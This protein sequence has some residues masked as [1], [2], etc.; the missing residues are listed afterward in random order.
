MLKDE[1][2]N[3]HIKASDVW[4][5]VWS[6]MHNEIMDKK[7]LVGL[8]SSKD[9]EMRKSAWKFVTDR[10]DY[11]VIEKNE[12]KDIKEFFVEL[13]SSEDYKTRLNA[14]SFVCSLLHIGVIEKDDILDKKRYFFDLLSLKD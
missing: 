7:E 3:E 10:L 1:E 4:K 8:L 9:Y 13:L 2:V 12:L 6:L 14:W 11:K 5:S